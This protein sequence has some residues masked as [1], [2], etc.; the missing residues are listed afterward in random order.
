MSSR[1][2]RGV[3]ITVE[4]LRRVEEAEAILQANG[5]R[6]VR[7]RDHGDIARIEIPSEDFARLNQSAFRASISAGL[8][9]AGFR[10]ICVDLEGYRPGGTRVS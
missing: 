8:R 1:I 9:Q 7:V 10:F 5:F 4:K 6:H 2:P 3:P